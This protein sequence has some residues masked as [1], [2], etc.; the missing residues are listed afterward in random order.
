MDRI[1]KANHRPSAKTDKVGF[2]HL[3][4]DI[5]NRIYQLAIYDHDRG[6]VFLPRALP[7]RSVFQTTGSE[8]TY[9][10]TYADVRDDGDKDIQ[11]ADIVLGDTLVAA[12]VMRLDYSRGHWTDGSAV[13]EAERLQMEFDEANQLPDASGACG[14][15]DAVRGNSSDTIEDDAYAS[16]IQADI[17]DV[18]GSSSIASGTIEEISRH[19]CGGDNTGAEC[20]CSC[21][22]RPLEDVETYSVEDDIVPRV[23]FSPSPAC[24]SGE[25]PDPT[26]EDCNKL[27]QAIKMMCVSCQD[28]TQYPPESDD[29][30][31]S[32]AKEQDETLYFHCQVDETQW[33]RIDEIEDDDA[34]HFDS[35]ETIGMLYEPKEPAI[36]L[37][38]RETRNECLPIYYSKNTFTWRFFW[39]DYNRSYSVFQGW[40]ANVGT[41]HTKQIRKITF[42]GRHAVEEGVEF[43]V[44]IDL[45]VGAPYFAVQVS[46]AWA[47][48]EYLDTICQYIERDL[49]YELW[50]M[51][52]RVSGI[53]LSPANLAKL[54][55]CFVDGMHRSVWFLHF[56]VPIANGM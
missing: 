34:E 18:S 52:P 56:L 42:E 51:L 19:L 43:A 13:A 15:G 37:A 48:D 14:D 2:L 30:L 3:N 35:Q 5:R 8:P 12:E 11:A 17:E 25:C 33:P 40:V 29:A 38:C 36:L 28:T 47:E 32:W 7:H 9:A 45:L 41:E 46:T 27:S 6:A 16:L 1:V 26:C 10:S 24:R 31:D 44:D 50:K 53:K 4:K 20:E 49:V 39:L 21:H 55:Q 23:S 54:G 22:S